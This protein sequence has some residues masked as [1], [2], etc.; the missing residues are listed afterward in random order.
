[1]MNVCFD[2]L[3][4]SKKLKEC[5]F[6]SEQAEGSAAAWTECL[7]DNV[8]TKR[9]ITEVKQDITIVRKDL[10]IAMTKF[11]NRL[12]ITLGSMMIGLGIFL[13]S[14]IGIASGVIIHFIK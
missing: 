9:D 3:K 8:A 6:S 4:Y 10:E 11:E 1:M 2:A 5:G 7:T 12:I 13:T 14:I